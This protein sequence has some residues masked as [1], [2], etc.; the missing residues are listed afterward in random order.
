MMQR[1]VCPF[2][3]R[4]TEGN[5]WHVLKCDMG[6]KRTEEEIGRLYAE[7]ERRKFEFG[8]KLVR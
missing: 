6:P 7:H 2:C 4:D 5:P 3:E 8:D 1:L